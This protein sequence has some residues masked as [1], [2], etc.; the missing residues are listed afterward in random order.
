MENFP[1]STLMSSETHV[2]W[3]EPHIRSSLSSS[4]GSDSRQ[5]GCLQSK[6]LV[7]AK[8]KSCSPPPV[9]GAVMMTVDGSPLVD[10]IHSGRCSVRVSSVLGMSS[11][12]RSCSHPVSVESS[13]STTFMI[14]A[15][16][17]SVTF[18]RSIVVMSPPLFSSILST[19]EETL[20]GVDCD[21]VSR[22]T[23]QAPPMASSPSMQ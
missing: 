7:P 9:T 22:T 18:D 23:G 3:F 5:I 6:I 13:I 4:Q 11:G 17:S 21:V 12:S 15:R 16:S 19:T 1:M 10:S 14:E 20:I 8:P 2:F